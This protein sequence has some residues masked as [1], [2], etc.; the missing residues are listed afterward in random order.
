MN[1]TSWQR[2]HPLTLSALSEC[3]V[4]DS[5]A[6]RAPLLLQPAVAFQHPQLWQL[7]QGRPVPCLVVQVTPY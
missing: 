3:T 4:R 1:Q 2:K 7:G 6:V 5:A